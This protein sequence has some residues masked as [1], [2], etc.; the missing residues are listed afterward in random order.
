MGGLP[1]HGSHDLALTKIWSAPL[2]STGVLPLTSMCSGQDPKN[3]SLIYTY[4][5]GWVHMACICKWNQAFACT[6][7]HFACSTACFAYCTYPYRFGMPILGTCF[8]AYHLWCPGNE[9]T[10]NGMGCCLPSG[11]VS[12]WGF[13]TN[14]GMLSPEGISKERVTMLK[15]STVVEDFLE[16]TSSVRRKIYASGGTEMWFFKVFICCAAG[17]LNVYYLYWKLFRL[18]ETLIEKGCLSA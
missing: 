18:A 3:K 1:E 2:K 4:S 9:V 17:H 16:T 7:T 8:E 15:D 14:S 11:A 13:S 12:G 10:F 6:V 5:N